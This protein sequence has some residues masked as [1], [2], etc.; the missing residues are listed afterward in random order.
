MGPNAASGSDCFGEF[1]ADGTLAGFNTC[2]AYTASWSVDGPYL[3]RVQ[4]FDNDAVFGQT[5]SITDLSIDQADS[6]EGFEADQQ[7]DII[8]NLLGA[9][10]WIIDDGELVLSADGV[11]LRAQQ[12]G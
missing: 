2:N 5:I 8:T 9:E 3:E 1:G 6:P 12:A 7:A 10:R 11:Y 4:T